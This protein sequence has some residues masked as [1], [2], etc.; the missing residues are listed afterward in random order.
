M[1]SSYLCAGPQFQEDVIDLVL[2][3]STKHLVGFIQHKH[4]DVLRS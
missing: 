4:F 3:P 2:E 1:V